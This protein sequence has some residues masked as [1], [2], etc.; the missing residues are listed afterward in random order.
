MGNRAV[1]TTRD[2]ELAL[3]VHWNG[4]RQSIEGFLAYCELRG[5]RPPETDSFGWARLCQVICNYFGADG[6][7]VGISPYMDDA[8][9]DP[10]DNGI[11][12]ISNWHIVE[13]L[14]GT[15]DHNRPDKVFDMARWLEEI[16]ARQ[17]EGQRLGPDGLAAPLVR[18]RDLHV[19]DHVI[20]LDTRGDLRRVTV[21][22]IE[23]SCKNPNYVAVYADFYKTV[24]G[25][26]GRTP[27]NLLNEEA[28]RR[29][30]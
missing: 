20:A 25:T 8:T 3:Y 23:R 6:L 2:R 19:G 11:Y 30:G 27:L 5:F 12:V 29:I 9:S 1:I 26:L 14:G 15:Y 17:P 18:T 10:G 4:G 13:R 22:A 16:D 28:Y 21:Y 24:Y 7:D